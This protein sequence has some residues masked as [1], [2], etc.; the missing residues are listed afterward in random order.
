MKT[1][2]EVL[3]RWKSFLGNEFITRPPTRRS[4]IIDREWP[5]SVRM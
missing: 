2:P 3:S 4:E 5:M 1:Y